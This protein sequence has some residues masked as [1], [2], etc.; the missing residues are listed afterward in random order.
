M[1]KSLTSSDLSVLASESLSDQKHIS[2]R[3]EQHENIVE[4]MA[5]KNTW[6]ELRIRLDK[7]QTIDKHLQEEN[8]ERER[9]LQTS[10]T[11]NVF[12]YEMYY[13]E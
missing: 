13:L 6:N 5:N 7:N 10:F 4:H 9:A 12:S 1:F 2:Q 11:Q 3:L 8:Y